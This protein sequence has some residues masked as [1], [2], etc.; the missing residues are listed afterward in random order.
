MTGCSTILTPKFGNGKCG[1]LPPCS[2][3]FQQQCFLI[4]ISLVD[5]VIID[6]TV[7]PREHTITFQHAPEALYSPVAQS[8][9]V[10]AVN[11]TNRPSGKSHMDVLDSF[12][13]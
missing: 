9:L 5:P 11:S 12:R 8:Y 10:A 7:K 3:H 4:C 2:T 1:K 13:C 6:M